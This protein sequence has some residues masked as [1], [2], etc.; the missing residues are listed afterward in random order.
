MILP[1]SG[2]NPPSQP[3]FENVTGQKVVELLKQSPSRE[4]LRFTSSESIDW[5]E[6]FEGMETSYPRVRSLRIEA[7]QSDQH[8]S[9]RDE[10]LI[11]LAKRFPHLESLHLSGCSSLTPRGLVELLT[12]LPELTDLYLDTD[13]LSTVHADDV[14]ETLSDLKKLKKVTL[15]GIL[16]P[17]VLITWSLN[18]SLREIYIQNLN[19]SFNALMSLAFFQGSSSLETIHLEGCQEIDDPFIESLASQQSHLRRLVLAGCKQATPKA[20]EILKAK[21]PRL[22][23]IELK[24]IPSCCHLIRCPKDVLL[25]IFQKLDPVALT[26]LARTSK[27]LQ[28]WAD[29]PELWR[30]FYDKWRI[31]GVKPQDYKQHYRH[32]VCLNRLLA[33]EKG[34]LTASKL[35]ECFNRY[36]LSHALH[37]SREC[38]LDMSEGSLPLEFPYVQS[39]KIRAEDKELGQHK[40][41]H[42]VDRFPRLSQLHLNGQFAW[43]YQRFPYLRRLTLKGKV[44]LDC[45]SQKLRESKLSRIKIVSWAKWSPISGVSLDSFFARFKGV[46]SIELSGFY[47]G[48][49]DPFIE[50]LATQNTTHL[51]KLRL[52]RCSRV[53]E[54]AKA[55]LQQQCPNVVRP[56]FIP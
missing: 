11:H 36:P 27:A 47:E 29:D 17:Y 31:E 41:D 2:F 19:R 23:E 55:R 16:H 7:D 9:I 1:V 8:S 52:E 5:S 49:E 25:L 4:E 21:C 13:V 3:S 26:A 54:Q 56:E 6:G 51:Q 43:D 32:T 28:R 33:R 12:L 42:F 45:Y 35:M 18:T 22:N 37:F 15:I 48:L 24:E 14:M 53:S 44:D 39:V 10:H 34:T 20:Y 40:A 46:E 50:S 30:P 38:L